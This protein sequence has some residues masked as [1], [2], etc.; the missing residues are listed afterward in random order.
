MSRR[1][2]LV[3]LSPEGDAAARDVAEHCAR[4]ADAYEITVLAT[5]ERRSLFEAA[6]AAFVPFR[7]SGI[8]GMGA[9][10]S[11]LRKTVTRLAPTI[12]HAHGYPATSVALGTFPT[13]LASRTIVTFHDPL[14][15]GEL[16]K[17]LVERKLP[18]YVRRAHAVTATYPSL[19]ASTEKRFA[20]DDGTVR[21]IPHGVEVPTGD[22]P[23]AR[24]A[25][26]S[27]PI[28][29]W[30]GALA[31]DRAWEV[32]IDALARTRERL[33]DARLLIAGDG[34][35]RQFVNAYVRTNGLAPYVTFLGAVDSATFFAQIDCLLVPISRD[36]QPQPLLEGLAWGVPVIAANA[37]ALADAVGPLETGWLVDDDAMGFADGVVAAWSGID[38]AFAGAARERHAAR[39]QFRRESVTAAYL[40]LYATL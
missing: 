32:A 28:V 12:V 15:E 37:G 18:G 21:L 20:I 39:E 29:G 8:F 19:V 6:G 9:S 14:R 2:L 26:R 31:A 34:R 33:P 24:P 17:R 5:R 27:G 25:G 10:I 23:L 16:P 3:L 38:A 22:A 13:S 4:I 30:R 11:T 35:A 36:A 1:S 40:S 7:P